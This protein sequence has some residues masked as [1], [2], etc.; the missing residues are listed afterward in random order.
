MPQHV[1]WTIIRN[2]MIYHHRITKNSSI[3][4]LGPST[5]GTLTLIAELI[6][7]TKSSWKDPAKY[8]F[9]NGGKD[10]V[11]YFVDRKS[12]DDHQISTIFS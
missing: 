3:K 2:Y 10:S 5:V 9:A 6:F 1:D 11:P 8:S 4:G 7:G 12:Y